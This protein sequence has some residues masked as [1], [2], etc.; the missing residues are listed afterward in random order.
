MNGGH[1]CLIQRD[2]PAR[3]SILAVKLSG[4]AS[5]V[6]IRTHRYLSLDGREAGAAA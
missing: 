3:I 4:A 6:I 5:A 1:A 2:R